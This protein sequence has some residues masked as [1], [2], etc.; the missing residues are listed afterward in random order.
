[1]EVSQGPSIEQKSKS[2]Q[3]SDR[4]REYR[5]IYEQLPVNESR[6]RVVVLHSHLSNA[7][8][9]SC[10]LEVMTLDPEPSRPYMALSYVWG[11][12][13]ETK[14]INVNDLSLAVTSNLASALWQIRKSFGEVLLWVDAICRHLGDT[15]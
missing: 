4:L 9:L 8:P 15:T 14:D 11:D 13:S 1:M 6:T 5:S 2:T 7:A 10:S 3:A 12:A